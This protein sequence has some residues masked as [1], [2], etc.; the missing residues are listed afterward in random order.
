MVSRLLFS[1]SV[2][3]DVLKTVGSVKSGWKAPSNIAIVSIGVSGRTKFRRTL[4]SALALR[5]ALPK[6]QLLFAYDDNGYGLLVMVMV[7]I[8]FVRSSTIFLVR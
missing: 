4:R 3:P 7:T 8:L 2:T 6:R 5:N 1:N